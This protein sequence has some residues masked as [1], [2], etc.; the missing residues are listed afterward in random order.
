M[1][2]F[3]FFF[4][5]ERPG[6]LVVFL[7]GTVEDV[8]AGRFRAGR[9]VEGGGGGGG[10]VG[11]WRGVLGSRCVRIAPSVS[12]IFP[13]LCSPNYH[14][15]LPHPLPRRPR[16]ALQPLEVVSDVWWPRVARDKAVGS[17]ARLRRRPDPDRLKGV[18]FWP[19]SA[20]PYS[21]RQ[22]SSILPCT[23]ARSPAVPSWATRSSL[24]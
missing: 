5:G 23:T 15:L 3:L 16:L 17:V 12:S 18:I 7:A 6:V 20:R 8:A 2:L 10:G 4:L 24:P 9:A 22:C 13:K 21:I 11:G 14:P 19:P 1:K